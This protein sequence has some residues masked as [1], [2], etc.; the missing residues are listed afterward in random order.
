MSKDILTYG[1]FTATQIKTRASIPADADMSISGSIISCNNINIGDIKALIGESTAD[2]SVL[3]QSSL[4]NKWSGYSPREW[5]VSGYSYLDR[6]KTP[7]MAGYFAG[8]HHSAPAP[9]IT[10]RTTDFTIAQGTAIAYVNA[11]ILLGEIDWLLINPFVKSVNME[12]SVGGSVVDLQHITLNPS[13]YLVNTQTFHST[14]NTTGWTSLHTVTVRFYFG[15]D[16]AN[17]YSEICNIPNISSFDVAISVQMLAV[18]GTFNVG[19]ALNTYLGGSAII[20]KTLANCYVT[21]NDYGIDTLTLST[22]GID[23]NADGIGDLNILN[24]SRYIWVQLNGGTWYIQ[25]YIYMPNSA[26][27]GGTY[28]LPWSITYGDVVNVEI[29]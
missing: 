2:L 11:S 16:A 23:T 20:I 25:D 4:V 1:G 18:L 21:Q 27:A 3:C 7:Y 10:D 24:A 22:N 17:S 5:Y 6:P 9:Y 28:N 13:D 29:R 15:R 14:L 26:S 19:S 8:Y 12:V